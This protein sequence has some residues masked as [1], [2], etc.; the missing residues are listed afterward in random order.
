MVEQ[1]GVIQ[2]SHLPA[3]KLSDHLLRQALGGGRRHFGGTFID[4]KEY[5]RPKAYH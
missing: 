2:P 5:A 1:I 4:P 3:L